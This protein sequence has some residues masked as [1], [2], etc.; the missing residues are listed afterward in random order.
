MCLTLEEP[1]SEVLEAVPDAARHV[2]IAPVAHPEE[3]AGCN[4]SSIVIT[5]IT[6]RH[7]RTSTDILSVL[8]AAFRNII[9]IK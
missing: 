1:R 2:R 4:S 8:I 3:L 5:V 7:L 9:I 6:S